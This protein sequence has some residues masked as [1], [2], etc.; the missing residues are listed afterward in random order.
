MRQPYPREVVTEG[1]Y[2]Y[3]FV[4]QAATFTHDGT[5]HRIDSLGPE[6]WDE[7]WWPVLGVPYPSEGVIEWVLARRLR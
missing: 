5:D 6:T 4:D 1:D 2:E 3:R 7:S